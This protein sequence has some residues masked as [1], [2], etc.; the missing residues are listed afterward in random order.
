MFKL[1][2]KYPKITLYTR[3]YINALIYTFNSIL[4]LH[5]TIK[6]NTD[7]HYYTIFIKNITLLEHYEFEHYK[8]HKFLVRLKKCPYYHIY[9][10]YIL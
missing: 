5:L 2:I 9:K 1:I 7:N 6:L 4:C 8:Y 10:E 3:Y